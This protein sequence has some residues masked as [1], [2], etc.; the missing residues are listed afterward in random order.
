MQVVLVHIRVKPEHVDAFT[1]ATI[2]NASHSLQ[3]PGIARFDV[4]QC[5]E[6]PERFTLV[7]VYRTGE[8]MDAHKKTEHYARWRD[9]V[10]EMMAEPRRGVHYE[11]VFPED[12]DG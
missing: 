12:E 3:E 10:S 5:V 2:D 1:A 6:D 8:A 4:I 7:E 11:T 9:A